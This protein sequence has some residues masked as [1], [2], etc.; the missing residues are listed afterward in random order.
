M[1]LRAPR[2]LYGLKLG[3]LWHD[4][5]WHVWEG[6]AFT[7]TGKHESPAILRKYLFEAIPTSRSALLTAHLCCKHA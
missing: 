3:A 7:E 2:D 6:I 5:A 1:A 4:G